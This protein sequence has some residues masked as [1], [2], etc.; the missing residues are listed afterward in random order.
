MEDNQQNF[1]IVVNWKEKGFGCKKNCSYCN[2]M[3]SPLLP[4][5][6]Q[7]DEEILK[8]IRQC[9]KSFV[10]ISGGADPLYKF[11]ENQHKLIHMINVVKSQ[12]FKVRIITREVEHVHKLKGLV[13]Y[14][15][16]S[17]DDD[18]MKEIDQYKHLWDGMDVEYSMVL[19]PLATEDIIPLK[20]QYTALRVKL[21]KRL[22]LRE[23]LNSI[24]SLDMKALSFGHTGIVFVS[25]ELCLSSRYL[26]KI[27]CVGYDIVMD[28]QSVVGALHSMG[29]YA[30]IFGGLAKHLLS[31]KRHLE[32]TDIDVIATDEMVMY[33]LTERFGYDFKL[34]SEPGRYPMY[35]KGVSKR[36]GKEIQ[37]VLL[38]NHEDAE[39]FVF[40][41]QYDVDRFYF[42]Y[43]VPIFDMRVGPEQVRAAVDNKRATIVPGE[44]D[45]SLF[46]VNREHVEK[47]H[48][49]KLVKKHFRVIE[50]QRG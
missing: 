11:E 35:Y 20:A 26:S 36:A 49:A 39:K 5:G 46:Q 31:P 12:G 22:V 37:I 6:P 23:N 21:G 10:T 47:R 48:H 34:T 3:N 18:V 27:D 16:I 33:R 43:G 2:W 42:R 50:I 1:T 45:V 30:Y 14:V 25:K 19:P 28:T 29:R 8:F 24:Y 40:N 17:L 7:S 32:Y 4:H 15:S 38:N 9:K 41:S 13:S 44:R